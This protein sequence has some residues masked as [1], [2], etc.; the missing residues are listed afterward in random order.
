MSKLFS[1]ITITLLALAM[2]STPLLA[3]KSYIKA[4][5]TNAEDQWGRDLAISGDTMVIGAWREASNATGVDGDESDNSTLDA[6][7]AYV[8]T[9]V[10]TTWIQT[11]YLKASNTDSGDGFGY[12]VAISG[13]TI[14][15]GS[16]GEDSSSSGVNGNQTDN[17][18]LDSGAA[19]V[20]VRQGTTWV[21]EAYLKASN[22]EAGDLFGSDVDVS[23]NTV[24]VSAIWEDG[25]STG[26]NGDQSDNTRPNAG[27]LYAFTRSGTVWTQQSYLKS[28]NPAASG[29]FGSVLAIDG[30]IIV[31]GTPNEG[32][33][34][35]GVNGTQN[36][37]NFFESGAAYIFTR[38]GTSW[39]QEAYLKAS[40]NQPGWRFGLRVDV[41][42]E[43]VVVSAPYERRTS[44]G[45]NGDQTMGSFPDVGAVYV[46]VRNGSGWS[47][48]AYIKPSNPLQGGFFGISLSIDNDN[49]LVGCNFDGSYATGVDGDQFDTSVGGAGSAYTFARAGTNWSQQHYLKSSNPEGSDN[50]GFSGCLSGNTIMVGAVGEDSAA[51]G[52]NGDQGDNSAPSSGAIYEF[53]LSMLTE[54]APSSCYGDGLGRPCLCGNDDAANP[55]TGGCLN[56]NGTGATLKTNG[57]SSVTYNRLSF[58]LSGGV[59]NALAVLTSGDNA[60]GGGI[61]ILGMPASDGL[62][63]VGVN[64]RRHGGRNLDANG[65]TVN[66]WG[67]VGAPPAGIVGVSGFV[68]GQT[69][70][71]Q[72]RYREDPLAGPCG[73]GTNTSQA[74]QITF[75]P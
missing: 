41:S 74:I 54:T 64:F 27:A 42:G 68:P 8:F 33:G 71:F 20:F 7:A 30:D 26:E 4:S 19:Y 56:A 46:F 52:L 37:D 51:T 53:D 60:L 5:N 15:V 40:N 67:A 32:S 16:L 55:G 35:S 6:G 43:T 17:S 75:A 13:D 39:S 63:C 31:T 14:V 49:L 34:S 3:Q 69:R 9:R 50:F 29:T 24:V 48:E 22:S 21:Q 36:H 65:A 57:G 62:R 1:R 2:T 44:A 23:G 61:G 70:H 28:S 18:L 11:A 66:S 12:H 47:Q 38:T 59:P 10:G 58:D 72:V 73:L 45:V 25:G